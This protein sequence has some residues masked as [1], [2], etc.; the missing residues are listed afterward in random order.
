MVKNKIY[1]G[2]KLTEEAKN[3]CKILQIDKSLLK[4]RTLE[5][6]KEKGIS[7][8]VQRIRFEHYE[9]KRNQLIWQIDNAMKATNVRSPIHQHI[10]TNSASKY[11]DAFPRGSPGLISEKP[12]VPLRVPIDREEVMQKQKAKNIYNEERMVNVHHNKSK[13]EEET[14]KKLEDKEKSEQK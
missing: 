1:N 3:F 12:S 9:D 14:I 2:D 7:P 6:F 13:L 11:S 10:L 4:P 8:E 5:S